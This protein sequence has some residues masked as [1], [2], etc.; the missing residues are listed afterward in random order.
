MSTKSKL[1]I[2][3][4]A[5]LPASWTAFAAELTPPAKFEI[6]GLLLRLGTS[7]CQFQRNGTWY[8]ATRAR[9]HIAMKYQ[10]LLSNNA[11]STA[12]D[13]IALAATRSS[14]SGKP[15]QVKCGSHEPVWSADWMASQLQEIRTSY[16]KSVSA[17]RPGEGD[18][19]RT[20]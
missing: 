4:L 16:P 2:A 18:G 19:K 8:G 12:E 17:G 14:L 5:A 13:F 1:L 10:Q 20:N 11:V 9:E 15:Y 3:L 7:E 6:E